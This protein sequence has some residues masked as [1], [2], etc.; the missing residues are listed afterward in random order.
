MKPDWIK[1]L[2]VAAD[3][4]WKEE[5][6][7]KSFDER[8]HYWKETM[9]KGMKE[10]EKLGLPAFSVFNKSNNLFI[11]LGDFDQ[12]WSLNKRALG[13]FLIILNSI[14][15]QSMGTILRDSMGIEPYVK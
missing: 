3:K 15:S 8:C 9:E 4:F 14:I 10:Q 6:P 5:Y 12:K 11:F 7:K 1:A 13:E 2:E